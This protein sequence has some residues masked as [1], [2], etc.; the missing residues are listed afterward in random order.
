MKSLEKSQGELWRAEDK[1]KWLAAPN[2][3]IYMTHE[4]RTLGIHMTNDLGFSGVYMPHES[5]ILDG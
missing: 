4:S 2:S 5:R 1:A 3:A